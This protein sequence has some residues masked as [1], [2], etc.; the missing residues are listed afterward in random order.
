MALLRY[1]LA[2]RRTTFIISIHS[3]TLVSNY[4]IL[5]FLSVNLRRLWSPLC[6]KKLGLANKKTI[7]VQPGGKDPSVVLATSKKKQ[8]NNPVSL[9]HR[10]LLK[11]EFNKMAEAVTNQ[12]N[13]LKAEVICALF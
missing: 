1:S 9:F 13:P 5:I 10:S 4:I 8:Q 2:R 7:S 6:K 12:V 11:R 3:S